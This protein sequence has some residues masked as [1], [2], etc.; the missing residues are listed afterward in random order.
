MSLEEHPPFFNQ[1]L[2]NDFIS[3]MGIPNL[4]IYCYDTLK[5]ENKLKFLSS[6]MGKCCGDNIGKDYLT[7]NISN[8]KN[9]ERYDLA[10]LTHTADFKSNQL[11]ENILGFILV[12]RGECSKLP[13]T[14]CINLV[15]SPI[16]DS[17]AKGVGSIMMALYLYCVMNNP[18][19]ADKIGLLELANSYENIAG[20]CLYSKYG[21]SYDPTLYEGRCFED[22]FNL[23][24]I[25]DMSEKYGVENIEEAN[26][27]LKDIATGASRGFIKP[28]ICQ[29]SGG[30]N[31]QMLLGFLL[32]LDK[33][34]DLQASEYIVP[35]I[36]SNGSTTHYD[37][38]HELFGENHQAVKDKIAQLL[39]PSYELTE[40]DAHIL[41]NVY[42]APTPPTPPPPPRQTRKR[43]VSVAKEPSP[44]KQLVSETKRTKIT[45][46]KGRSSTKKK[47]NTNATSTEK[48]TPSKRNTRFSNKRAK[49]I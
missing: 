32:S 18:N 12:Q 39:T 5:S 2:I 23:P 41:N 17:R 40:E 22:K 10:L 3:R 20:L 14:Y 6:A 7:A 37:K 35:Y 11:V 9:R 28:A 16:G 25:V 26:Q 30:G 36:K 4:H 46:A 43:Q 47:S 21:F 19:V 24:M 49:S 15:C 29:V 13:N 48:K 38:L 31:K 45:P 42:S 8:L 33:L 27:K 44:V 1:G 34:L